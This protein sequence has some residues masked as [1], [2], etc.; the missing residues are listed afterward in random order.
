MLALFSRQPTPPIESEMKKFQFLVDH[1]VL[2][3]QYVELLEQMELQARTDGLTGVAN[4]RHFYER[5]EEEFSRARRHHYH[6]SV[7]MIDVDQFKQL[8]DTKGHAHGDQILRELAQLLKTN[9]RRMDLVARWGGDEFSIV[10][11]ETNYIQ[12][13]K[14]CQRILDSVRILAGTSLP[15][16]SISIGGATFPENG[17]TLSAN[18]Q[19]A[20]QALYQAKSKGRDQACHYSELEASLTQGR[21]NA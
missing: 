6:L 17:N 20:D 19:H 9:T 7:V 10:L 12:T 13:K 4:Y 18:L 3:L 1:S 8:N 16:F 2:A 21:P 5:L 11:P 14:T 15:D